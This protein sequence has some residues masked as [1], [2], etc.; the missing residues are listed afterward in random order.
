MSHVTKFVLTLVSVVLV[1]VALAPGRGAPVAEA[2]ALGLSPSLSCLQNGTVRMDLH[3]FSQNEG[4]QWVDLSLAN[5]GFLPGTF[6]GFGPL[7]STQPQA[8]WDGLLSG[9][10]RYVVVDMFRA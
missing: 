9:G 7:T 2:K 3:W 1:F 6:L 4:T 8:V 5:N 10:V